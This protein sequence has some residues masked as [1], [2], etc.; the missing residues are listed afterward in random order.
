MRAIIVSEMCSR[1]LDD[2]DGT[3]NFGILTYETVCSSFHHCTTYLSSV[4][5]QL[6]LAL[7]FT[8][9]RLAVLLCWQVWIRRSTGVRISRALSGESGRWV[10][11]LE[12]KIS[13]HTFRSSNPANTTKSYFY[14][15]RQVDPLFLFI[16][17]LSVS[18]FLRLCV[19][20]CM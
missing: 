18:L 20:V 10:E 13:L 15:I 9:I 5:L 17:L 3:K 16:H 7:G 12:L 4:E 8:P 2:T 14:E 1:H 6:C 19:Q 11:K